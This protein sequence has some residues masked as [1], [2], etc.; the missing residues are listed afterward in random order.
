[1]VERGPHGTKKPLGTTS[2][3]KML[4]FLQ[5]KIYCIPN[6]AVQDIFSVKIT[7]ILII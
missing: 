6:R 2:G 4:E 1:M 7:N 5:L 3:Q